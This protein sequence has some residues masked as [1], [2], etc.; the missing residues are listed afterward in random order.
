MERIA[1]TFFLGLMSIN[2]YASNGFFP[3]G[4]NIFPSDAI[5]STSVTPVSEYN[6]I[7]K[8]SHR[9]GVKANNSTTYIKCTYKID[10]DPTNPASSWVWAMDPQQPDHY[11]IVKG[12]WRDNSAMTNMFYT[13]AS[14][15]ELKEICQYTLQSA[16]INADV[17]VPYAGDTMFSYYYNFWSQG[18]NLPEATLDGIKLDR[19][20]VFGDSLSDTINSYNASYGAL[21]KNSTWFYGRF[22][23]GLVWHEYWANALNIPSYSWAVGGAES[24]AKPVFPGFIE[25][26]HNFKQYKAY[27]QGYDIK[28]TL[29]AVLFGGNN[30][31][32]GNKT[33]GDVINNYRNGLT[34]LAQLGA[35]QITIL[36]LPDLSGVP[37]VREWREKDKKALREKSVVLNNRLDVLAE[38]L[39]ESWPNTQFIV[40]SLDKAF[41]NLI[42]YADK[43]GYVNTEETCLDLKNETLTYLYHHNP[44]PACKSSGGSFI[45]WDYMHLTTHAHSDLSKMILQELRLKLQEAA[46]H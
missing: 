22:S 17:V 18:S 10:K 20:V 6:L 21:P 41:D 25:Q 16:G 12:Y 7:L 5:E 32:S 34:Q 43:L 35:A 36:K 24:A 28:K 33:P 39:R 1:A 2:S 27:M 42:N 29:F 3:A 37:A 4:D 15:Q 30:F 14:A 38:E 46:H 44:R 45:F 8:N 40:L 11:A 13:T 9:S 19:L 23:N 31:I 26:L